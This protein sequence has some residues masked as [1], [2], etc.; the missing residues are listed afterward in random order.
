MMSS[1]GFSGGICVLLA[2]VA[3]VRVVGGGVGVG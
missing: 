3:G 1:I 2:I